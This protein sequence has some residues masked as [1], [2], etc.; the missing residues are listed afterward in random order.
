M[1]S[2]QAR[3]IRFRRA[4]ADGRL[5]PWPSLQL[6]AQS[7]ADGACEPPTDGMR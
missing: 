4:M 3:G 2:E 5:C 1:A 7:R 6:P